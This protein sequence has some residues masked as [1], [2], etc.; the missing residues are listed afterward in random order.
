MVVVRGAPFSFGSTPGGGILVAQL[1]IL[2]RFFI[3]R[4]NVAAQKHDQ[5]NAETG[6]KMRQD[7][8]K[9]FRIKWDSPATIYDVNRHLERPCI[10]SD[11]SIGGATLI[12]LRSRTIPDEFKLRLTADYGR[13]RACRV[14]WRTEHSLGVEFTDRV[15]GNHRV[16]LSRSV[17]ELKPPDQGLDGASRNMKA[18]LSTL[19]RRRS[20]P[21]RP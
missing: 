3:G 17:Q 15:K 4:S 7:R 20:T 9:A 18:G 13:G 2:S 10:V 14:I 1:Q 11:F 6:T 12:G 21:E 19:P 16:G 8:R 5:S